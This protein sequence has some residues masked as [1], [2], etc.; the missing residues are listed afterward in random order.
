MAKVKADYYGGE[1]QQLRC[2]MSG[3]LFDQ[4]KGL[5][6]TLG[7][8]SVDPELAHKVGYELGEI[9]PPRSVRTT[10]DLINWIT[11]DVGIKRTNKQYYELFGR[12]HKFYSKAF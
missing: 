5:S 9:N 7:G 12:Y 8:E 4:S 10:A 2:S 6:F 11:N 1:P 3:R